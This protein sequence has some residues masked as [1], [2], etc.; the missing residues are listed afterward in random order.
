MYQTIIRNGKVVTHT[1]V[2]EADV[3]IEDGKIAAIGKN[4][5]EA[6]ETIDA[7]GKYIMPGCIDPHVHVGIFL[8]YE[9]DLKSETGA[10]AAGGTTTIIHYLIGSDPQETL[11]NKMK[12]PISKLAYC[13]VAFHGV[14]LFDSHLDEIER[15]AELGVHSNKFLMAYKGVAGE[16]IGLKGVN[17]DSGFL[18][19]AFEKMKAIGGIPMIHAEHI[20]LVFAVEEKFKDQNTL[21]TWADARP[22]AAEE[23]DLYIG[24]RLA[25]EVG[26]PIYQVHSSIGNAADIAREFRQ[27]GN[28]VYIE[29]CPHYLVTN[30]NG[31]N[32]KSPLLGKINPPIRSPKDQEDIWK[33]V[34]SGEYDCIGT[35]SANNMYKNKW[36][37][38][39]IWNIV[40]DYSSVEYMLPMLLSEGVNK[41]KLTLP[42]VV[43]MTSYNTS[44]IFGLYP[45]KGVMAIG[46]DADLV[47]VDLN[48]KKTLTGENR[49]SISDYSLY[50]GWEITGM[51]TM[52]LIRGKKVAEDDK[53]IGQ[54]GYGQFVP[55]EPAHKHK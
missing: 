22:N 18:Y 23:I 15:M 27:R 29:T 11:Y 45:R 24:C 5:G 4:L 43:R 25:E 26:V 46:S 48:R 8:D 1:D 32:L 50:E 35:D 44:K 38:G 2:Y 52:T 34:M 9:E 47:I 17:I 13:D 7:S 33:G 3:A 54:P 30:Y 16:Q 21:K 42:D 55:T 14:L 6:K 41:G 10:A 37:D 31:E 19:K 51:P 20:E 28:K 36:A 53:I 40:L 39:N 12:A 49:H